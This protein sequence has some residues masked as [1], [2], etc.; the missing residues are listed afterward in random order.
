[1]TPRNAGIAWKPLLPWLLAGIAAVGAF[2]TLRTEFVGHK[3]KEGH[4]GA[5][6]RIN[7][8]ESNQAVMTDRW[9][10]QFSHNERVIEKLDALKE[11]R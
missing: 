3:A 4:D 8:I 2:F 7:V 11:D 5:V 6:T 9:V 1:M 10:Q